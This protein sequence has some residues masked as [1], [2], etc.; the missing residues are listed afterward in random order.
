MISRV[1]THHLA[2]AT[3]GEPRIGM[4]CRLF[5]LHHHPQIMKAS[6]GSGLG[7]GYRL[8]E[9]KEAGSELLLHLIIVF[10]VAYWCKH[11]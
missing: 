11:V 7:S 4:I 6:I 5:P 3:L 10:C 2:R 9:W 8:K 1:F